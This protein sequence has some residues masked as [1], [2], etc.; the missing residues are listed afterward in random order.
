MGQS[1][2]DIFDNKVLGSDTVLGKAVEVEKKKGKSKGGVKVEAE[3]GEEE[4]EKR[5]QVMKVE[6]LMAEPVLDDVVM[7]EEEEN[8]PA[9]PIFLLAPMLLGQGQQCEQTW[10]DP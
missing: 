1:T 8:F 3:E 7:E 10:S 9:E 4:E 5:Q 6:L 2:W